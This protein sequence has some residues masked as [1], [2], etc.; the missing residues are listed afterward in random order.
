MKS[1]K[2]RR[3][4]NTP[5]DR[6]NARNKTEL[7]KDKVGRGFEIR[8]NYPYSKVIDEGKYGKPPG[9]ANGPKTFAGYSTQAP[10]GIYVPTNKFVKR[11]LRQ[12]FRRF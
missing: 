11:F 5:R 10:Q 9:S 2:L 4:R 7:V 8:S 3:K 12:K 6:G 1:R